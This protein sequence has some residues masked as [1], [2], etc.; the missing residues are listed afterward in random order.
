MKLKKD[1][2]NYIIKVYNCNKKPIINF[3]NF[4]S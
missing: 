2:I 1:E 3:I 4:G